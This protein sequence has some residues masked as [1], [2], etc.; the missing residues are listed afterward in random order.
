M[1]SLLSLEL[2][3]NHT[4]Y[5]LLIILHV[6]VVICLLDLFHID[7]ATNEHEIIITKSINSRRYKNSKVMFRRFDSSLGD[8]FGG[9]T[10]RS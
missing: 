1:C 2:V 8:K 3:L 9:R 10:Y 6:F 4:A 5:V 7:I